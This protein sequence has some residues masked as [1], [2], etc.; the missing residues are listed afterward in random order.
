[1]QN[2]GETQIHIKALW[3]ALTLCKGKIFE[4][5]FYIFCLA[6]EGEICKTQKTLFAAVSKP[7]TL[8]LARVHRVGTLNECLLNPYYG[9]ALC[10]P[11]DTQT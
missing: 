1:M 11:L 8:M 2:L 9:P 4:K 6:K 7:Q 5:F 10:Q 3:E